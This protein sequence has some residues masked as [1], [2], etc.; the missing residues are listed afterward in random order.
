MF[1]YNFFSDFSLTVHTTHI[2]PQKN[3][4]NAKLSI[5]QWQAQPGKSPPISPDPNPRKNTFPFNVYNTLYPRTT[6][7]HAK[8]QTPHKSPGIFTR[9]ALASKILALFLLFFP[10]SLEKL[11]PSS[12]SFPLVRVR[13]WLGS[14]HGLGDDDC[15]S[16]IGADYVPTNP[17]R[18]KKRAARSSDS[19]YI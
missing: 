1:L 13:S 19:R 15:A 14:A 4:S 5:I 17:P 18:E 3:T 8:V 12:L 2:P 6:A 7:R 9:A 16:L 10:S 11:V